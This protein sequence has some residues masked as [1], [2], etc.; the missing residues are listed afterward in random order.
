MDL[1]L[2]RLFAFSR[3][4][5]GL[6]LGAALAAAVLAGGGFWA[7]RATAP[8]PAISPSHLASTSVDGDDDDTPVPDA[9]GYPAPAA[10]P[11]ART[12]G[13]R[14]DAAGAAIIAAATKVSGTKYVHRNNSDLR[15]APSY[16]AETIK[17]EPK[18]A[19]LQVVALSDKWAE[20]KDGDIEG[21]M[22]A[23]VL[24]DDPPDASGHSR[25]KK[26][27]ADGD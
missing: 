21:W 5:T 4:R 3:S 14:G 26:A 13:H 6:A 12:H 11:P 9:A 7:G 23:S 2:D 8:V 18:G 1:S 20:V 27:A 15:K 16:A 24:K 17:K 19:R 10:A 25:K 22:R